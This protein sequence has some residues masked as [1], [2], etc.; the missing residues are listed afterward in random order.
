MTITA[1]KLN[2]RI[3]CFGFLFKEKKKPR[4][5]KKEKLPAWLQS[6]EFRQLKNGKDITAP[7][8]KIIRNATLTNP[9]HKSRSYAYCSDTRYMPQLA[10]VVGNCD[11][12]YHEA[13]F[14][15]ENIQW[16]ESTFHSTTVEAATLA[17]NANTGKLLIGHFSARY[18]ELS[19][20]LQEAREIFKS[21][22]LAVEGKTYS[23]DE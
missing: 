22:E 8:G 3:P 6:K 14:L 5:L 21:T 12:L 2:H 23:V 18:K 19:P 15:H 16:A 1:F 11:L 20:F 17:K 13:T 7:D 4:R 9:P 10:T